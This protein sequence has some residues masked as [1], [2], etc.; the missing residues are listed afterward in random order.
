M[1]VC[2]WVCARVYNT[3]I[4]RAHACGQLK[5]ERPAAFLNDVQNT[6]VLVYYIS[7]MIVWFSLV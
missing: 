1:Y 7:Y 4:M 2:V 6:I 5:G 3:Y